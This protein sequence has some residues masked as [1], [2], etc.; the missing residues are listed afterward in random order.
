MFQKI[1]SVK[2]LRQCE[3]GEEQNAQGDVPVESE[4]DGFEL[5]PDFCFIFQDSRFFSIRLEK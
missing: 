2:I 1:Y 5:F 4:E 3:D